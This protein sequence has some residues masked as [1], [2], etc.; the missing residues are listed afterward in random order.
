MAEIESV[1]GKILTNLVNTFSGIIIPYSGSDHT[2]VSE[3]MR[4]IEDNSEYPYIVTQF[5]QGSPLTVSSG[6]TQWE[7]QFFVHCYIGNVNDQKPNDAIGEVLNNTAAYIT[8]EAMTDITR[9]GNAIYTRL[10]RYGE[11]PI[12]YDDYVELDIWIEL[13]IKVF[14]DTSNPFTRAG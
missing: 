5:S 8:K 4:T 10:G 3:Y 7:L 6:S 11:V 2:A 12:Q 9:G 13:F 1:K 14:A